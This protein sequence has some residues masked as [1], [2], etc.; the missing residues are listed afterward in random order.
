M[1]NVSRQEERGERTELLTQS[2]LDSFLLY[3][4]SL[5]AEAKCVSPGPR[6]GPW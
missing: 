1:Q 5:F 4:G 2:N 3:F 6:R